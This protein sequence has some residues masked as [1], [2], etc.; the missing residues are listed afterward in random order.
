[1]TKRKN[2]AQR[3]AEQRSAL[4][5]RVYDVVSGA[6]GQEY[7]EGRVMGQEEAR[8]VRGALL[9][10]FRGDRLHPHTSVCEF[11]YLFRCPE[12]LGDTGSITNFLFEHGVRA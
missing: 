2:K 11:D 9:G 10:L 8:R 3:E 4:F 1:M 5:Q 6:C 7:E 12:R